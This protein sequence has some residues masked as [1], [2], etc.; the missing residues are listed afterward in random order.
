MEE[1]TPLSLVGVLS[2]PTQKL[3]PPFRRVGLSVVVMQSSPAPTRSLFSLI[4]QQLTRII[5]S[6]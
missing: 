2:L 4:K 1:V 5:I 6:A 3:S